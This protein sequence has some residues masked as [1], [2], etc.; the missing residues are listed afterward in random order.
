[1]EQFPANNPGQDDSSSAAPKPSVGRMLRE[2]RG[3]LGLSI[4]DVAGQTKFAQRQIEALEADDFQRLP[5]MPFVRGFVRSYAKILHLDA[6]T[7]LAALPQT[8]TISTRLEPVSVEVPFPVAHSAQRQNVILLGAALLL[9]VLVVA[10][11]V[12]QFTTPKTPVATARIKAPAVLPVETPEIQTRV[13]PEMIEVVPEV[14]DAVSSMTIA[15]TVMPVP[16]AVPPQVFQEVPKI[17]PKKPSGVSA[18]TATLRLTFDRESWVEIKD[19]D[20]IVLS[21]QVNSQ[22]SEL[23]LDGFAPFSL[24][25]GQ[26]ASVRLFY[27]GKQIDLTPYISST[28]EVARLT[29]E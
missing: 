7:L 24:V 3:R 11:A 12:W 18:Q 8:E 17:Q 21:S 1:M 19:K 4:A 2:A 28:S 20:D 9:A 10:F 27:K 5:E 29:L 23:R 14:V 15:P 25:I 16:E 6:Q 13:V 26:A 22:G